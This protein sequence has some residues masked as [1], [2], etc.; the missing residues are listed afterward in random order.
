MNMSTPTPLVRL[1]HMA[2]MCSFFHFPLIPI[3]TSNPNAFR[4]DMRE[5]SCLRRILRS[6]NMGNR[7]SRIGLM[8]I[9]RLSVHSFII[10]TVN[11]ETNALLNE[12]NTY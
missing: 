11:L 7:N 5:D 4:D 1:L 12:M 9:F 8:N 6:S 2:D 3:P 10:R